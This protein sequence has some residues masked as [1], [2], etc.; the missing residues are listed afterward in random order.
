MATIR[1]AASHCLLVAAVVAPWNAVTFRGVQVGD[2]V[3][4][5]SALLAL[6]SQRGGKVPWVPDWVAIGALG[7]VC[8]MLIQT[9]FPTDS[10]YMASRFVTVSYPFSLSEYVD[11][12]NVSRG[13]KWILALAVLPVL[14]AELSRG[15]RRF[16]SKLAQ[17][18][19]LGVTISSA[20]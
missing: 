2:V 15:N 6:I 20:V 14:V 11:E 5:I 18:W 9:A 19:V 3:L 13:I 7:V 1:V 8:V 16:V 4:A 10:G 12:G 17:S